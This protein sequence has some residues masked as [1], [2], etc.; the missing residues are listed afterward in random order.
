MSRLVWLLSLWQWRQ[1][2]GAA[3]KKRKPEQGGA[4]GCPLCARHL[5]GLS[6]LFNP[7]NSRTKKLWDL[8]YAQEVSG[9]GRRGSGIWTPG[10][11]R[12]QPARLLSPKPLYSRARSYQGQTPVWPGRDLSIPGPQHPSPWPREAPLSWRSHPA[13][14]HFPCIATRPEIPT[15]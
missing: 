13:I 2:L 5:V 11:R 12:P 9:L 8:I 4:W 1:G 14:I 15:W 10:S 3:R 6:D 7:Q